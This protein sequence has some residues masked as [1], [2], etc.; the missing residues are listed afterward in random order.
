VFDVL[1]VRIA[2]MLA[3]H[4]PAARGREPELMVGSSAV[5]GVGAGRFREAG[6][7]C[8][9]IE[10]GTKNGF[11][12]E[13]I[14]PMVDGRKNGG[15]DVIPMAEANLNNKQCRWVHVL[16]RAARS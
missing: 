9:V 5:Q 2:F 8:Q 16:M 4:H 13:T 15:I 10:V 12:A 7:S 1:Q 3:S 11:N 6:F 14:G